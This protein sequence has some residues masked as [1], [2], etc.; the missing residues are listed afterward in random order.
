MKRVLSIAATAL[1]CQGAV[2]GVDGTTIKYKTWDGEKPSVMVLRSKEDSCTRKIALTSRGRFGWVVMKD[3]KNALLEP[4]S[5]VGKDL[6]DRN[7]YDTDPNSSGIGNPQVFMVQ[8]KAIGDPAEVQKLITISDD[9]HAFQQ[10]DIAAVPIGAKK[11]LLITTV[12]SHNPDRT[13]AHILAVAFSD[14]SDDNL[15]AIAF[16]EGVVRHFCWRKD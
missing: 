16:E 4:M 12:Y 3:G 1:C 8:E 10:G 6:L 2:A 7:G 5:A 14:I 15:R 9:S 11:A 13:P